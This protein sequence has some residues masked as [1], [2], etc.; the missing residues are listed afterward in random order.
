M[1]Y[2]TWRS[3]VAIILLFMV[4]VVTLQGCKLILG[5]TPLSLSSPE[6]HVDLA[7]IVF[8]GLLFGIPAKILIDQERKIRLDDEVRRS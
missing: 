4:F 3:P 7:I 8:G 1:R 5:A 6:L 2:K